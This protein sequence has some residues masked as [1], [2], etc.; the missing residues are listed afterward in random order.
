V[1]C[2]LSFLNARVSRAP[3]D[4]RDRV[5]MRR[6]ITSGIRWLAGQRFLLIILVSESLLSFADSAWWG[7]LVL[8]SER[9]LRLANSE[10]GILL[11]AGALGGLG[12]AAAADRLA[13]RFPLLVTLAVSALLSTVV[14]LLLAIFSDSLLTGVLLAVSSGALAYS[15]VIAVSARQRRVPARML[16]RLSALQRF[17]L[18][19]GAGVGALVGGWLA[20]AVTLRAPFVLAGAVGVVAIGLLLFGHVRGYERIPSQTAPR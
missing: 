4:G 17:G 11:A 1:A 9:I 19:A 2:I 15:N 18:F 14:P 12:G 10:Y 16:G 5:N 8:Y 3:R 20:T 13:K 6:E 7:I